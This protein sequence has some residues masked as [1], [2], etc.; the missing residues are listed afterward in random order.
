MIKLKDIIETYINGNITIA[1]NQF[2]NWEKDGIQIVQ[3]SELF[4]LQKTIKTLKNIGLSDVHIINSFH[5]YNRQ[6]ID[7]VKT[8]L[9]HNFY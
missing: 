6:N 4:G 1:K 2:S 8:I 9:L 7:E 5:D 3:C